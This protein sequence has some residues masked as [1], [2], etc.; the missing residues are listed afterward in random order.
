MDQLYTAAFC[1]GFFS[2]LF[3]LA[4]LVRENSTSS[5]QLP[6]SPLPAAL[7]F[8]NE[9]SNPTVPWTTTN[10]TKVDRE[11]KCKKLLCQSVS[12]VVQLPVIA[13][14]ER[15]STWDPTN[16]AWTLTSKYF[17]TGL[18]L[19]YPFATVVKIPR[20]T[21]D[22]VKY[23]LPDDLR[24]SDSSEI[25][26]TGEYENSFVID[27]LSTND[28]YFFRNQSSYWIL[29]PK[30]K[31][32]VWPAQTYPSDQWSARSL[33]LTLT[34]SQSAYLAELLMVSRI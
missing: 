8:F 26:I 22:H 27:N 34:D 28:I 11:Q 6:S 9:Q 4:L 29:S 31:T 15:P 17:E 20:N 10:G 7:Q 25:N 30:S 18:P 5:L 14:P 33:N 2:V 1:A 24:R 23:I 19:T 32:L 21:P 12:Y 16:N 13:N 3:V